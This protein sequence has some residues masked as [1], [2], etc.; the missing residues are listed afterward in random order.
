MNEV[1]GGKQEIPSTSTWENVNNQT[2]NQIPSM[3][4]HQPLQIQQTQ[5][6]NA[7]T[8][9]IVPTPIKLQPPMLAMPQNAVEHCSVLTH[10][11]QPVLITQVHLASNL[12]FIEEIIIL[13]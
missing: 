7:P 4:H 10:I 2:M 6:M 1:S 8:Q 5:E 12:I 3:H 13:Y 11:Q 9:V